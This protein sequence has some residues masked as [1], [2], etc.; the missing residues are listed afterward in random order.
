P[1]KDLHGNINAQ[2][3][4]ILVDDLDE[5]SVLRAIFPA[6]QINHGN[7][8]PSHDL[9]RLPPGQHRNRVGQVFGHL[10]TASFSAFPA[11]NPTPLCA[12]TSTFFPVSGPF[13][14]VVSPAER[15]RRT[16]TPMSLSLNRPEVLSSAVIMVASSFK[17]RPA[18][19]LLMSANLLR[20]S[21][22]WD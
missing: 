6:H 21:T 4:A 11:L 18:A 12:A 19:A 9:V 17:I 2:G 15:W 16:K 20:C 13:I 14:M 22:C 7:L 10:F 5:V 1:G 3:V 8:A